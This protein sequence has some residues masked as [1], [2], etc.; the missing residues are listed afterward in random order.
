MTYTEIIASAKSLCKENYANSLWLQWLNAWLLDMVRDSHES[1]TGSI[2]LVA[3]TAEYDLPADCRSLS[4]VSHLSGGSQC[5]LHKLAP[6]DFRSTGWKLVGGK[7]V[8]QGLTIQEGDSL[9]LV[10]ER[11][12]GKVEESDLEGEPSDIPPEFHD[13]GVYF[14]AHRA[15][16]RENL[17]GSDRLINFCLSQYLE[18]RQK[19]KDSQSRKQTTGRIPRRP[20]F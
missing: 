13:S 17:E 20:Y 11:G 5:G 9:S 14:L 15:L 3:D 4:S 8:L 10:Y 2:D 7:L 1:K 6:S 19:F 12:F 18:I 16:V